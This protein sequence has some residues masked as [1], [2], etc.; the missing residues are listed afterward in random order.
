MRL[1][2]ERPDYRDKVIIEREGDDASVEEVFEMVS[3]LL[4]GA[5]YAE[6]SVLSILHPEDSSLDLVEERPL[7][8]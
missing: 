3:R 4:M 1:I 2:L 5:G 8:W 7:K 6:K